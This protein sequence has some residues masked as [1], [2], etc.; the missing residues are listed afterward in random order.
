MR[1]EIA[2]ASLNVCLKVSKNQ[3]RPVTEERSESEETAFSI[4]FHR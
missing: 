2:L 3:N 1:A 4:L